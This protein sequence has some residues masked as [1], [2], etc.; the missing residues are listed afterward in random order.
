MS[1]RN[2]LVRPALF[3]GVGMT[4]FGNLDGAQHSWGGY[5]SHGWAPIAYL[6]TFETLIRSA[7][8][9]WKR[10]VSGGLVLSIA[11]V[12]MVISFNTLRHAAE[13]WGWDAGAAWLFPVIVDLMVIVLSLELA[14]S[15]PVSPAEEWPYLPTQPMDPAWAE[16]WEEDFSSTVAPISPAPI[17]ERAEMNARINEELR[18][19]S[20]PRR[21]RS[22]W[23]ARMVAEMILAGAKTGEIEEKTGAAPASIGRIKKVLR[24]LQADPRATIDPAKEKVTSDNI[25]MI[26]ELVGQ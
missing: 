11:A 17:E 18:S 14:W 26:R 10:L 15:K 24:T 20:S 21:Q 9:S 1:Y 5:L 13:S 12:A 2:W 7:T 3:A 4:L 16:S 8:R 23:D 25:R 6:I 22:S 19:P